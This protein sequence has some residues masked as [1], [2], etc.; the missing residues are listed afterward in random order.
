MY[1]SQ[2]EILFAL[3]LFDVCEIDDCWAKIKLEVNNTENK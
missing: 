3:F 1:H 2:R